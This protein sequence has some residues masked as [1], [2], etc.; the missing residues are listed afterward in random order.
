MAAAVNI[1]PEQLQRLLGVAD[2]LD[3]MTGADSI[4]M[5]Q[6]MLLKQL[7]RALPEESALIRV[8]VQ[9]VRGGRGEVTQHD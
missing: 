7:Q 2:D 1:T 8:I 9:D 6:A 3:R 4:G 5:P